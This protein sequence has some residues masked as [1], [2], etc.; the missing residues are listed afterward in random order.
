MKNKISPARI[1]A[2]EILL[3]IEKQQ[4]FSSEMLPRYTETLSAADRGL[5]YE[6]TLGVLRRKLY[7]DKLVKILTAE[8]KLDPEVR[9]I[10]RIALFQRIFLD[11][12]PDYSIVNESVELVLR[13]K[14]RSA[15]GFVNAILRRAIRESIEIEY[16]SETDRLSVETSHPKWLVE[17]WI[18]S[19]GP[20]LTASICHANNQ[21]PRA[22]FRVVRSTDASKT[23]G[24]I[25]SPFKRSDIIESAFIAEK[26]TDELRSMM[27][28]GE[29]Y[30]QDEASQLVANTIVIN[31]G[32]Q[33]LDVC[34]APGGKTALV[35]GIAGERA[36]LLVAGDLYDARVG[37]L[38]DNLKKQYCDN[39]DL[40][41]YDAV[42]A[43]PFADGTFDSILVD[44]PCSG[45]GTISRNP[46][47][48]YILE[49]TDIP[50]L[51]SKQIR[52]LNNAARLVKDGGRLYYSTC[53][54]EPE[55]DESV[56]E[57][58]LAENADFSKVTVGLDARFTTGR[59]FLRTF[60]DRDGCDGFFMA[61]FQR[62][63][64]D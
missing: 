24:N 40:V 23:I 64:A 42:A 59:G 22:A 54:M 5:C 39:V 32:D 31:K 44:A 58:F 26:I 47:L 21:V 18:R 63:R 57:R 56:A 8:K 25:S 52:I 11:R 12:I 2:F 48:R 17:R 29:L 20:E 38:S 9:M 50:E 51:A 35:A 45:T 61:I 43:L 53:S 14:K 34:A 49:E 27:D 41:Q 15:K 6:I 36:A 62:Q 3:R 19:F 30:F 55:E 46:E 13:A 1:A 4:A 10:L 37:M 60:P 33:F 16:L 7:L 28:S